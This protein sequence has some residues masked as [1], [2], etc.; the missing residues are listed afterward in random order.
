[1]RNFSKFT[2]KQK[3]QS[4]GGVLIKEKMVLKIWEKSLLKSLFK[5]GTVLGP[6][7]LL[8]K[9]PTQV[10]SYEICNLFKNNYFEEHLLM[11]TSE[12]YLEKDSNI[13]IFL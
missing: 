2:D 9:S 5:K 1:M 6:A 11:P 12:L 8:R 4:S 3:K 7:N 13:D 10:V